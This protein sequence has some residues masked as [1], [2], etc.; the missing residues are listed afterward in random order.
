MEEFVDYLHSLIIDIHDD[1]VLL[2]KLIREIN[3]KY[4]K[5]EKEKNEED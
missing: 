3:R 2:N 5:L 4:Y 1:K